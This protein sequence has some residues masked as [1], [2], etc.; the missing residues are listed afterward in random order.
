MKKTK[1]FLSSLCVLLTL[2]SCKDQLPEA[3][4]S[5]KLAAAVNS[6]GGT[7]LNVGLGGNAYTAGTGGLIND[8]GLHNWTSTST[9]TSVWFRLSLTGS[10]TVALKGSVP[11]GSSNIKVTING[12]VFNK[13]ITGSSVSTTTI[14]TVNV[15]SPGYV[16]VDIQGVSKTGSYFGDISDLVISGPTVASGVQYA[17]D[18]SNYYW[19][20]RGPSCHLGYSVPASTQYFYSELNVPAGQDKIGSYFMANGFSGGYFGMQVNSATERRILFS[21]WDP[22]TGSTTLV[23]KGADV[24]SNGFGGEGTG[25]QSYLVYNWAAD[26]T[27]KFL[28]KAVP[29]ATGTNYTAWFC[30]GGTTTWKLIAEW[31]RPNINSYLTGMYSFIENFNPEQGYLQR[32][33]YHGNQ[34][35]KTTTGSWAE[36]TNA[37]FTFDATA[38]NEQRMDYQGGVSGNRFYLRNGGFFANYTNSGTVLT[39]TATGTA[40]SV[41]LT[42]L[43]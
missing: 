16:R 41:N 36:I 17:T 40:P 39:R 12:T 21:V 15:A 8:T 13:T 1:S 6:V 29:S 38:A 24:T 27:H 18:V 20:R 30:A 7:S 43:P 33:C 5:T 4:P 25:G 3:A 11:T 28:L 42:T 37:T 34:W 32:T 9:I 10:L 23:R 14:G 26:A 22:E 2:I 31:R 19:S 35:Y